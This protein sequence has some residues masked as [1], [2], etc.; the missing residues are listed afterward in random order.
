MSVWNPFTPK[1][2]KTSRSSKSLKKGLLQRLEILEPKERQAN[3]SFL[4]TTTLSVALVG[5]RRYLGPSITQTLQVLVGR[6]S[7]QESLRITGTYS[8]TGLL[9][10]FTTEFFLGEGQ[11]FLDILQSQELGL[12]GRAKSHVIT[13]VKWIFSKRVTVLIALTFFVLWAALM[14]RILA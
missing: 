10:G 3:T 2:N 6:P 11:V 1:Q 7:L 8:N 14:K 9:S 13:K 12:L 4:L 5:W